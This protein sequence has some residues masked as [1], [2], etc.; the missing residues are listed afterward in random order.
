MHIDEW[1]TREKQN[2]TVPQIIRDPEPPKFKSPSRSYYI[3]YTERSQTLHWQHQIQSFLD[4]GSGDGDPDCFDSEKV[5]DERFGFLVNK[6]SMA[7]VDDVLVNNGD[8]NVKE[9]PV[10]Q[11]DLGQRLVEMSV[12][13]PCRLL[14]L[15][16]F[17][18]GCSFV[19][20]RR[21]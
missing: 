21:A 7:N 12:F 10:S 14:G 11:I 5:R 16:H 3:K 4:A 8:E 18:Q 13:L 17:P 20:A 6:T 15:L 2:V 1:V 19:K 9:D